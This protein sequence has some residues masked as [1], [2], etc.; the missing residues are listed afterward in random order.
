[1][2]AYRALD[3]A[4]A[5]GV[6]VRLDGKNLAV[7]AAA[8]PPTEVI[9]MLCRHKYSII[10]VLQR[11]LVPRSP[12]QAVQ[13]WDATDWRTY[14]DERAAIAEFDGRF[15]RPEAE[16]LAFEFCLGEWLSQNTVYSPTDHCHQCA[17]TDEPN[18]SPVPVGLAGTGEVWLHTRCVAA[19][20]TSRKADALLAL[21]AMGITGPKDVSP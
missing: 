13:P 20:C 21:A 15:A 18:G 17:G 4:R 11:P 14:F 7:S 6:E 8:E 9:D 1:M 3:A 10:A 2:S 5:A 16:V 12:L 19:W